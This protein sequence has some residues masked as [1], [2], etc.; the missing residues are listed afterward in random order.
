MRAP[1][2]GND[3]WWRLGLQI[4]RTK[5]QECSQSKTKAISDRSTE[6]INTLNRR[7]HWGRRGVVHQHDPR[8]VDVL[9]KGLGLERGTSLQTPA[10]HDVTDEEPEPLDQMQTSKYR[11]QLARRLFLSQDRADMSF[12]LPEPPSQIFC[13]PKKVSPVFETRQNFSSGK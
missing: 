9:V 8:H 3:T 4:S 7:L 2:F 1:H 5:L 13:K 6:S 12:V 10:V 11:S